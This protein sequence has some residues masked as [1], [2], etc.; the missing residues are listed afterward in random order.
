M[1]IYSLQLPPGPYIFELL[2]MLYESITVAIVSH[3]LYPAY[4]Y[5]TYFNSNVNVKLA[6]SIG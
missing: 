4:K 6:S 3:L 2:L 1:N 5:C